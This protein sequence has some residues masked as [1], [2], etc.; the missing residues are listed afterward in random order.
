MRPAQPGGPRAH[1]VPNGVLGARGGPRGAP[2]N[3]ASQASGRC[4]GSVRVGA[5]P[6]CRV[7]PEGPGG[8]TQLEPELARR[9]VLVALLCNRPRGPAFPAPVA[10]VRGTG[11]IMLRL[12][13]SRNNTIDTEENEEKSL[14]PKGSLCFFQCPVRASCPP[15]VPRET[16]PERV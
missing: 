16:Q 5:A 2:S 1:P 3:S 8:H 9:V 7:L 11:G 10:S 6:P 15:A 12:H 4:Q 14:S 13:Y